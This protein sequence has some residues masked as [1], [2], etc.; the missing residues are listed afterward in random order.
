MSL[1]VGHA[2]SVLL[3]FQVISGVVPVTDSSSQRCP[4]K[5]RKVWEAKA[6]LGDT[7]QPE[8]FCFDMS[9]RSQVWIVLSVFTLL[10]TICV[11]VWAKALLKNARSPLPVG[12]RRLKTSFLKLIN[13]FSS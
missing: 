2:I 5:L 8:I 9:R 6:F 1:S 13:T 4:G 10:A 7:R 11:K 12:V 3:F